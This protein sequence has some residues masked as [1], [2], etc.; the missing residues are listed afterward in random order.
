MR[1][2]CEGD[3]LERAVEDR[4]VS[5]RRE[6]REMTIPL[7]L[8]SRLP[9]AERRARFKQLLGAA[10]ERAA[11]DGWTADEP[12]G[13]EELRGALRF[14]MSYSPGVFRSVRVWESVTVRLRRFVSQDGPF[15]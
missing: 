9:L 10:L 5:W 13:W 8:S 3:M 14:R 4:P 2:T 11:A 7:D 15:S 1:H 6:R 12:I